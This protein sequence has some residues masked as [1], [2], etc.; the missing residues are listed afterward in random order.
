[1]NTRAT[2]LLLAMTIAVVGGVVWLRL[3]LPPT[4]EAGENRRYAAVF[5]ADRVNEVDITRGGEVISLRR[6]DGE[7]RLVAPV[8]DRAAADTAERLVLAARFLDVRD[9]QPVD[10]PA[11]V[12]ESGLAA[13]RVRLDLR[14]P[15]G[16]V[17]IDLGASTALPGEVFARVGGQRAVLRVPDSI[18][19][20]AGAPVSGFRDPR[21]TTFV[22][23]DVE[24]FTV[25]RA[26]GEMTVRRERGRWF[27]EKPVA[28][29]ADP[30]AVRQFLEP[31]LGLRI[32]AFPQDA[33]PA[34]PAATLPGETAVLSL[35]PRGGADALEL[36]VIRPA[37]G[38]AESIPAS[39]TARGGPLRVDPAALRLFDVSPESLRDRS[40]GEVDPD[41]VD[42]IRIE[43]DGRTLDLRREGEGWVD[44]EG[45]PVDPAAPGELIT[46]FN[47]AR[48]IS[49]RTAAP[50]AE[51]GL[52]PPSRRVTFASWLSENTAEDSAGG[53]VLA[54]AEFGAVAPDGGVYARAAG[55]DET[56][57]VPPDL[58][59]RLR[60]LVDSPPPAP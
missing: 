41:T 59:E 22:A 28:A 39:L 3:N 53:H 27:I 35:T 13:P 29:A 14:G 25:R 16:G 45:R 9:R 24:K 26:D 34:A 5:E 50:P 10:D 60:A 11:G 37:P 23:D 58:G 32:T 18:L 15:D 2:L 43:S 56:V 31:L 6:E 57:T 48:V 4:A 55:R 51:T 1:M 40:L 8:A 12:A 17:R 19:E 38:E 30:R 49:F 46:A 42:R 7:W 36:K 21:L 44:A 20:L 52:A 33:A 47:E 54:G